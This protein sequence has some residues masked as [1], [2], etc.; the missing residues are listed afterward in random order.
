MN[1]L[2]VQF[3]SVAENKKLCYLRNR[4]V[5]INLEVSCFL[6]FQVGK[7]AT[8]VPSSTVPQSKWLTKTICVLKT[9]FKTKR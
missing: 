1:Y 8:R 5:S 3:L 7:S 2:F 4:N 6:F 9:S